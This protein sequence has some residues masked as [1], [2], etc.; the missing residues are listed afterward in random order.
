VFWQLRT[1]AR[2]RDLPPDYGGWKNPRQCFCRWRD[3]GLWECLLE[4]FVTAP[5]F[6]WLFIDATHVKMHAHGTEAK[7]GTQVVAVQIHGLYLWLK[8]P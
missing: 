1:G 4:I 2:W 8:I 5:D 6:E 3:R 7:G